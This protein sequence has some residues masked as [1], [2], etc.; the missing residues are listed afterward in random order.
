MLN[1]VRRVEAT[2][3]SAVQLHFSAVTHRTSEIMRVLTLITA[4]FMPLTLITGVFGMNFE[5][6][7]GLHSKW[8]FWASLAGMGTVVLVLL[9][10]FRRKRWV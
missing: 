7:P 9:L 5:M 1:H 8:G 2:V 3:E 10:L 6:I 4:I